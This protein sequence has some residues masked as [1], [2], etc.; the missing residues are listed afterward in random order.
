MNTKRQFK[1]LYYFIVILLVAILFGVITVV[2]VQKASDIASDN[3]AKFHTQVLY[4]KE[5]NVDK[6]SP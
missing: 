3:L 4:Q 1:I 2:L 5:S 6:Q